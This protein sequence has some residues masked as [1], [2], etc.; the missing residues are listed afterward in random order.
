VWQVN[1]FVA[2]V[3]DHVKVVAR[4][5]H[6]AVV[7]D[8]ALLVRDDG[9]RTEAFGE[10]THVAWRNALH[11]FDAVLAADDDAEHVRHVEKP[12]RRARVLV[13]LDDAVRVLHRHVPAAKRHHLAAEG[14]VCRVQRRLAQR[15][16][17]CGS[18]RASRHVD[19]AEARRPQER[20]AT[21]NSHSLD[22]SVVAEIEICDAR[23]HDRGITKHKA[24]DVRKSTLRISF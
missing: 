9:Q 12:S 14:H 4:I 21:N 10:G 18:E 22:R 5:G 6:D 3:D 1:S 23:F 16:V 11:E 19:R 17:G 20:R 24:Q 8:A 2:R 7:D 15:G 13:R